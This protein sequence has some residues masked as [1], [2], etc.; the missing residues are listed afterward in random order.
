MLAMEA[1]LNRLIKAIK[2]EIDAEAKEMTKSAQVGFTQVRTKL[3]SLYDVVLKRAPERVTMQGFVSIN[4]EPQVR[5]V[6]IPLIAIDAGREDLNTSLQQLHDIP[7]D[8]NMMSTQTLVHMQLVTNQELEDR[9][10]EVSDR[11]LWSQ[12]KEE[13]AQKEVEELQEA[14]EKFME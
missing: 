1:Q 2:N 3:D 13:K 7:L 12:E 14:K 4:I 8:I 10:K 9:Q 11:F 6:Q 5:N